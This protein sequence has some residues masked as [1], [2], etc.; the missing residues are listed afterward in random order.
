MNNTHKKVTVKLVPRI[1]LF[2]LAAKFVIYVPMIFSAFS[3]QLKF[4]C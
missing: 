4:N 3:F 2:A 1:D